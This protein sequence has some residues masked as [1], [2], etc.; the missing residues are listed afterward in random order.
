M[1]YLILFKILITI[2]I[3]KYENIYLDLKVKDLN[4]KNLIHVLYQIKLN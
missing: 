4:L 3:L 1:L 2:L